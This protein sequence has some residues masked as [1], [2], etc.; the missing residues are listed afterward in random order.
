M[1]GEQLVYL[2][3]FIR[4]ICTGFLGARM[5][6]ALGFPTIVWQRAHNG[7]ALTAESGNKLPSEDDALTCVLYLGGGGG[8]EKRADEDRG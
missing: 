7:N 3:Y 6:I 8:S 2:P 5:V 4:V 1:T